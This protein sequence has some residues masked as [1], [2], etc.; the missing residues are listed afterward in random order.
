MLLSSLVFAKLFYDVRQARAR[1]DAVERLVHFP[2]F[3]LYENEER[4]SRNSMPTFEHSADEGRLKVWLTEQ[5]GIDYFHDVQLVCLSGREEFS[6]EDFE[7]ACRLSKLKSLRLGKTAVTDEGFRAVTHLTSIESF[8]ISSPHLSDDS[9][10]PLSQ[11]RT[12]KTLV[13]FETEITD[14][15]L[16]LLTRLSNLE[17]LNLRKTQVTEEGIKRFQSALPNCEVRWQG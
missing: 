6:D 5:L 7:A 15:G 14:D 11:L 12:L 13:L 3:V 4:A 2:G 1:R 9:M 17:K 8:S 10:L 16:H